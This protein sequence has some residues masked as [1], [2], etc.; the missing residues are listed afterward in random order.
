MDVTVGVRP[1][2]ICIYND[3]IDSLSHSD[4]EVKKVADERVLLAWILKKKVHQDASNPASQRGA[5]WGGTRAITDKTDCSM[6]KKVYA[7]M[8]VACR[9]SANESGYEARMRHKLHIRANAGPYR[10][11]A[12]SP[13]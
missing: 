12:G 1:K 3:Y 13:V 8:G 7:V 6:A 2:T 5:A 4:P 9:A 10:K 11:G